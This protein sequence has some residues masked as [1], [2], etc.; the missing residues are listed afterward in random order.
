[1][2]KGFTLVEILVVIG[3]IGLIMASLIYFFGSTESARSAECLVN[4]KNLANAVQDARASTGSVMRYPL[5]GSQEGRKTNYGERDSF[6]EYPGWISWNSQGAYR[7]K[8]R[9][10]ISSSSWLTSAYCQDEETREYCITNGALYRYVKNYKTYVCPGHVKKMPNDQ[11]PAWSY[12]MNGRFG[13]D[14]S[15]GAY[16]TAP[17]DAHPGLDIDSEASRLAHKTLLF[18]ELQWEDYTENKPDFSAGTGFRNDCTLQFDD[19][20]GGE[21]IG[22]NHKDGKD[23]VAHIVFADGHV[24]KIVYPKKGLS[25][26]ELKK[27][28]EFLCTGTD[29]EIRDGSVKEID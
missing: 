16:E 7:T 17:A 21:M 19:E 6:V 29:Y 8:P 3:I 14:H 28:T 11:R 12:V 26:N 15:E 27:L 4:M 13:Y 18:A 9:E 24:D 25:A 23:I 22:F 1:M 5:A 20:D 10:H 2:K